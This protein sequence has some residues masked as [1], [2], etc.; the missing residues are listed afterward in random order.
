MAQD[1]RQDLP[2]AHFDLWEKKLENYTDDEIVQ[3]LLKVHWTFFP[4]ADQVAI[5]IENRRERENEAWQDRE[6]ERWLEEQ[7]QAEQQHK[8][9]TDADYK[10]LVEYVRKRHA[11]RD[12]VKIR[13]ERRKLKTPEEKQAF[14]QAL[15]REIDQAAEAAWNEHA[16]KMGYPNTPERKC[17]NGWVRV[18]EGM[19]VGGNPVDPI[20]GAMRRCT[21]PN[22]M[23]KRESQNQRK[24]AG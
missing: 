17:V 22:C 24:A 3:A 10:W 21:C 20:I 2:P 12:W 9:A 8:L 23:A 19:T 14:A 16:R 15:N 13:E 6:H 11:S 7:R 4:S 1:M 5:E 18:F